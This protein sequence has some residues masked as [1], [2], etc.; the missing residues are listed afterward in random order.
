MTPEKLKQ[1]QATLRDLTAEEYATI[2]DALESRI[3][4]LKDYHHSQSIQ[5]VK[6]LEADPKYQNAKT[7][8]DKLKP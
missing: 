2:L 6:T 3:L 8:L 1:I 5:W 7:L 4:T